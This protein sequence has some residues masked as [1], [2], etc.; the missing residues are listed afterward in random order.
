MRQ[1]IITF[2]VL[3]SGPVFAQTV[4]ISEAIELLDPGLSAQVVR[5]RER[6]LYDS[7]ICDNGPVPW[8][9]LSGF[10]S[11]VG[12]TIGVDAAGST[13]HVTSSQNQYLD[14]GGGRSGEI[15]QRTNRSGV[16]TDIARIVRRVCLG[17]GPWPQPECYPA[18]FLSVGAVGLDVTSGRI[19][20][21]VQAQYCDPGDPCFGRIGVVEITGLPTLFDTFLTFTNAQSLTLL[22][23]AHPD[24]FRAADSLQVWTGDL[25]SLPDWSQAQPL[26]CQAA[27]SPNAGQIVAIGDSLPS[28]AIGEGRY[29]V[30]ASTHGPDRRLG[31]QYNSGG[32]SARNNSMLPIC[33]P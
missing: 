21:A 6:D 22:T 31:R 18:K 29:Y 5:E 2:V 16:S 12:Y 10:Y 26:V 17:T 20:L 7:D 19:M 1:A 4:T 11:P 33:A 3:C 25:R 30:S 13:Y 15:L 8:E 28:P 9:C 14:F 24:G 27:A 23:P 32:F